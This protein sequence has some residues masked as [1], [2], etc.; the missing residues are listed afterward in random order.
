MLIELMEYYR[1]WVIK[2][3]TLQKVENKTAT[4]LVKQRN[5]P[6]GNG[7]CA[8]GVAMG[9]GVR[10]MTMSLPA[11]TV[12]ICAGYESPKPLDLVCGA[13]VHVLGDAIAPGNVMS[14]I[15]SAFELAKDL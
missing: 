2:C 12:V 6:N 13:K 4:V 15:W 14:T 7:R 1:V 11:D 8:S 9:P 5:F 3:A 10:E